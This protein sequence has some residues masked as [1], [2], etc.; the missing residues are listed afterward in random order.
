MSG[1]AKE[2]LPPKKRKVNRSMEENPDPNINFSALSITKTTEEKMQEEEEE[3]RV[4]QDMPAL[5]D[6]EEEEVNRF[7][8][9]PRPLS[10][11]LNP[12]HLH[13]YHQLLPHP[14]SEVPVVMSP[15][16]TKAK[17]KRPTGKERDKE[18]AL[19]LGLLPERVAALKT[20]EFNAISSRYEPEDREM[21]KEIR[22]RW[23]NKGAAQ[24]CRQKKLQ[25]IQELQDLK[26][27]EEEKLQKNKREE[28]SLEEDRQ[29]QIEKA[30]QIIMRVRAAGK[31]LSCSVHPEVTESCWSNRECSFRIL[32]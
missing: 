9:R 29:R 4:S 23:R 10:D 14:P 19:M 13:H 17:T 24:K 1:L 7:T 25:E 12:F 30:S 20:E 27:K 2:T 31:E 15:A 3:M 32:S 6:Q 26:I 16:L 21:L 28:E 22:K 8:L 11:L 5:A 18:N